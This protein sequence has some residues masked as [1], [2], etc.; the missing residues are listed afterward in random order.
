MLIST[1]PSQNLETVGVTAYS[2]RYGS[3]QKQG[4]K[5]RQAQ[6]RNECELTL[7]VQGGDGADVLEHLKEKQ[8]MA[9]STSRKAESL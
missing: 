2:T 4:A 6:G 7:V 1:G 3:G 8:R 5:I 9:V